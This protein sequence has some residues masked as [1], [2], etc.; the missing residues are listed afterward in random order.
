MTIYLSIYLFKNS[1]PGYDYISMKI[2]KDNI[3]ILADVITFICNLSFRSGVYPER[4]MV[5]IIT[6][7]YKSGNP[8]L[9]RNYRAISILVAFSKIIEKA[10]ANRFLTYFI[11]KSLFSEFQFAYTPGLSTVD[12]IFNFVDDVYN[13]FDC[14]NNVI[15]VCLDLSKAFD[16]LNRDILFKKL[17]HYGVRGVELKW[18]KSYLP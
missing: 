4:L 9:F 14:G 6:C 15:G 7:I 1:S 17:E 13:E 18:F 2:L 10:A 11:E 5:A 3:E 8:Q 12:A 16:S